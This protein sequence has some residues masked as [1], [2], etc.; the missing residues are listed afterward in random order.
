MYEYCFPADFKESMRKKYQSK[1]QGDL[2]VQDYFAELA[3]LRRRL[4]EV[5]DATHVQRAWDGAA[6]YIR[7]EWAIKGILP[8]NTTIEELR[9]TALDI[10]RAHKI[11][12]SI[13]RNNGSNRHNRRR[14]SRSPNHRNNDRNGRDKDDDK[15]H[16]NK[17]SNGRH[18]QR[19]SSHQQTLLQKYCILEKDLSQ[20]LV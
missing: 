20:S 4:K 18:S 19:R 13:E 6:T 5:N 7:A 1:E 3:M 17:Q 16:E 12:K 8:E 2:S 9:E 14:R 10:E 15:G 11:Q